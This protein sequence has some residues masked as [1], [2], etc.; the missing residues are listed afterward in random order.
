MNTVIQSIPIIGDNLAAI[1]ALCER[2]SV[3]KL[4]VFGSV[5]ES[6]FHEGSDIDFTVQMAIDDPFEYTRHYFDL[7]DGLSSILG[8]EIDLLE[9]DAM[10]NELLKS[11]ISQ[12]RVLIYEQ[13]DQGVAA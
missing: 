6:T 3:D 10:E 8:R 5:L 11:L 7:L 2:H 12:S 9:F 13:Q 4:Y 1:I